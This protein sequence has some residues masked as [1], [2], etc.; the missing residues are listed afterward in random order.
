MFASV[1][2]IIQGYI[3]IFFIKFVSRASK[4][5]DKIARENLGCPH[6][7]CR[8][9]VSLFTRSLTQD[10]VKS[11]PGHKRIVPVQIVCLFWILQVSSGRE[12][13]GRI[14]VHTTVHDNIIWKF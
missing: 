2:K 4:P 8:G 10:E 5:D 14:Q 1:E 3:F 6:V 7:N 12:V 13:I 11:S 9:L